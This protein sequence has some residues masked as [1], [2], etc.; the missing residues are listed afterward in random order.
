MDTPVPVE[1]NALGMKCPWPVL[2]AARA[3][4]TAEAIVIAADDPIAARELTALASERG[5]GLCVLAEKRFLI[6]RSPDDCA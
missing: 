4:R 3:M 1:V 2:R 5:W 6:S